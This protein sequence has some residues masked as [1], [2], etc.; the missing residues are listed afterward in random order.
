MAALF[1]A[2][3]GSAALPH[4]GQRS[5]EKPIITI[6]LD[7]LK[8]YC[9]STLA[10]KSP[11]ALTVSSGQCSACGAEDLMRS[12]PAQCSPWVIIEFGRARLESR[13]VSDVEIGV[14]GEV[15]AKQSIGV[16]VRAA[17]PG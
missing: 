9:L 12:Q 1:R 13:G 5:I 2:W 6:A 3:R 10:E 11:L 7:P 17:L 8:G 15:L 4:K 14:L 16:F